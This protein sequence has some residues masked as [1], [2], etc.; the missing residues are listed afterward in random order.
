MMA[1]LGFKPG[2]TLGKR[3]S[4]NNNNETGG[5]DEAQPRGRAEPLNLVFKEDRSGIGLENEKKR[6]FREEAEE[7]AKKVKHEEGDYRDRVRIERETR[8]LEAQFHG[9]QKVA[10][11]LDTEA[12]EGE[13]AEGK[14]DDENGEDGDKDKPADEPSTAQPKAKKIK[15]TLQINILYRGLVRE[16]QERD[17]D[18]QA[19]HALQSSL[20][21]SFFPTPQ[22]PGFDDPTLEREDKEALGT[23]RREPSSI[24]E[25]EIEEEDPELDEFNSLEPAERLNR[26]VLYLREK[27]QYCFWCKYRYETADMEGCP[28]T[29][30][31]DHD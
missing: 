12:E 7:A 5:K 15:P 16:R 26:L 28:G 17:R 20:P 2:E 31:E 6:R 30:E 9:A 24:V 19:R 8:R 1:K 13:P 27:H 11:R 3:P 22:L 23:A 29:T 25:E 10:E 21:S 14:Q 4:P 18:I